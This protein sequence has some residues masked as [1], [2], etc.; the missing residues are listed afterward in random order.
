MNVREGQRRGVLALLSLGLVAYG[1][2]V[3]AP[4]VFQPRMPRVAW[5][6]QEAGMLA[7]EIRG[8]SDKAGVYFFSP[9]AD[10]GR[11]L[12]DLGLV[13]ILSRE[14]LKEAL[15]SAAGALSLVIEGGDVRFIETAA[16]KRLGLG[17]PIDLHRATEDDLALVPGI[18][19]KMASQIIQLR[20]AKGGFG[21]LEDLRQLPG[22]KD[23][24]MNQLKSYLILGGRR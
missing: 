10:P 11:L 22:V 1:A 7:L 18:G 13:G 17:L 12:K 3:L 5:V 4:L 15:S 19:I 24:K 16:V 21:T 14:S 8:R 9:S 6:D 20:E 23:K 2:S